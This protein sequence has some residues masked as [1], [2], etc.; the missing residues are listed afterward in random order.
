VKS[1]SL[2]FF[3]DENLQPNLA[4]VLAEIYS[5]HR[6]M[7]AQ[8]TGLLGVDDIDLFRGLSDRGYDA[9]ITSIESSLKISTNAMQ[10]WL[11]VCIGSVSQSSMGEAHTNLRW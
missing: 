4:R 5:N 10:S 6:F 7:T 3:I 2:E 9:I 1:N 11:L 8:N